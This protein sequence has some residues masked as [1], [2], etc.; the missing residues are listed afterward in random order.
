MKEINEAYQSGDLAKLLAIEKQQ[1]LG[2]VIN[3]DSSDD[4][5]RRCAKVESEN[6]FLKNQLE[7][8][9]QQLRSTKKTDQGAMTSE[10]KRMKKYGVDPIEVAMSQVEA[11]IG[12][13]EQ[14]QQFVSDFRDRRITI[15]DF[16]K[17]PSQ[18]MQPQELSEEELLLEFLSR[19]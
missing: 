18:L 7:N 1:E 17:G 3:R 8:L 5:T 9:K 6:S 10:F 13:V 12:V 11:Q 16:L 14:V 4:I 19:Y 15:K 2:E